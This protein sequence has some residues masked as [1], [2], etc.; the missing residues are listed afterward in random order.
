[1]I[2]APS[3]PKKGSLLL[4]LDWPLASSQ[5]GPPLELEL[6]LKLKLKLALRSPTCSS[7]AN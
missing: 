2:W 1:M 7:G 3:S 4:K 6:K 5:A